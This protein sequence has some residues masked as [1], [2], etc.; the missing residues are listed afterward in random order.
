MK[1]VKKQ[2]KRKKSK[3]AVQ[4]MKKKIRRNAALNST[5]ALIVSV[6]TRHKLTVASNKLR[7]D[8]RRLLDTD[9]SKIAVT[10]DMILEREK[11]KQAETA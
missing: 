10:P 6:R 2:K 9:F 3:S 1:S 5:K 7:R 8:V 4:L 11:Q